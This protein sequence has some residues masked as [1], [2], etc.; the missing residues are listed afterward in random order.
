MS[1]STP[2]LLYQLSSYSAYTDPVPG[3]LPSE[4]WPTPPYSSGT[5]FVDNM[6]LLYQL[7]NYSAYTDPVQG[8]FLYAPW[9]PLLTL[10][11]LENVDMTFHLGKFHNIV[12]AFWGMHVLPA[13]HSYAWLPR[14]CDYWTD[15]QMDGQTRRIKWSLCDATI[16]LIKLFEFLFP[17]GEIFYVYSNQRSSHRRPFNAWWRLLDLPELTPRKYIQQGNQL[18]S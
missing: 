11:E 18:K 9:P 1:R 16:S 14:K 13:K 15:R 6:K 12:T 7:S 10:Q 17:M 5:W 3:S 4:P 2:V 8:K